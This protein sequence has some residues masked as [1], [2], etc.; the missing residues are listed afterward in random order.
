[1]DLV[2]TAIGAGLFLLLVLG[3]R[4]LNLYIA[5]REGAESETKDFLLS[6]MDKTGAAHLDKWLLI[7]APVVVVVLALLRMSAAVEALLTA[8]IVVGIALGSRALPRFPKEPEKTLLP[9]GDEELSK[10]LDKTEGDGVAMVEYRW[11]FREHPYLSRSNE[12]EFSFTI[13]FDKSHY[14]AALAKDHTVQRE[15]DYARFVIEDL[16]TDEVVMVAAKLKELHEQEGYTRFQQVCNVLAFSAQ[17]RYAYDQESKG[18]PEYPRYPVEMLWDREGDCECHAILAGA[19]LKLL[20]FDVVLLVLDFAQ[21]P[22]HVAAGVA[23]AEDMPTDLTFYEFGGKRYFYCEATPP[24]S[25]TS[26]ESGAWAW[27]IGV[28]PF[29][30]P[31]RVTGVPLEMPVTAQ[32]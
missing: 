14:E 25:G 13:P 19:L 32:S 2:L 17:F 20:G 12:K 6:L 3:V 16:L 1:M 31:A 24:V 23:G 11:R 8:G 9:Y 26:A 29:D 5:Q 30:D 18:V 4:L 21:G 27:S 10:L 15:Q 22:G 7:G 28:L